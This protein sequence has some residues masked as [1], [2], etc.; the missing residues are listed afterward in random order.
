MFPSG[1]KEANTILDP[2]KGLEESVETIQAAHISAGDHPYIITC[3][4]PTQEE[5]TEFLKTG[6]VWLWVMGN[7]TP[8]VY[9]S[10]KDPF[11]NSEIPDDRQ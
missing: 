4:K 5:M 1:F 10:T 6:R 8:P 9:L 2:P 11:L 7:T 3:W